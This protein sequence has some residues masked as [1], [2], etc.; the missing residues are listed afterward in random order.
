MKMMF[1]LMSHEITTI[2]KEDAKK[3]FGV[4]NFEVVPSKW[5]GQIPPDSDS[6][7]PYTQ[8]IKEWLDSRA[9]D[10]DIL[11]VQGDFGATVDMISYARGKNM[12]PVYATT[13]RKA[14]ER[15]ENDKIITVRTF[16]H[17]RFREYEGC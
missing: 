3:S 9:K 13:E 16:E 6:V 1:I 8:E 5:W 12:I 7:R 17:V 2:Q 14:T 15:V 10:G 4:D 11:L